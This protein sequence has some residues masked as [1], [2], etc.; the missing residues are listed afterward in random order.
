M[1]MKYIAIM[2]AFAVILS[3]FSVSGAAISG[4]IVREEIITCVDGG[5]L[6]IT[7]F[8]SPTRS[9]N[10]KSGSSVYIRRDSDGTEQW[11]CVL[12]ATF[13][14]DG[15]TSK[16]TSASATFTPANSN[17]YK[18]TLYTYRAG[19]TAYAD[20]TVGQKFLGITVDTFRYTFTLSCDKDGN[21]S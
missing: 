12:N 21:L 5:T 16:A 8:E 10:T 15:T 18:D 3:A 19:N 17:W 13:T 1:K 14:Y 6:T 7:V 2:L 9:S 4:E 20:L 11:R